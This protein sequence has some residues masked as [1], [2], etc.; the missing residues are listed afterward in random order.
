M[1]QDGYI[2]KKFLTKKDFILFKS[3]LEK[4]VRKQFESLNIEIDDL[5]QYHNVVDD[6]THYKVY[7]K[8][9]D[10]SFFDEI[11]FDIT[12]VEKRISEIMYQ[13]LQ[14]ANQSLGDKVKDATEELR[15]SLSKTEGML[16]NINKSIFSVD[17]AGK[18]LAP[19]SS[20][21]ETLFRKNIEGTNGLDLLFFHFKAESDEKKDL[22]KSFKGLFGGT[23]GTF[24]NLKEVPV[25]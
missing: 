21:S 12:L 3:E 6:D 16:L 1:K 15:A 8:L 10:S 4:F 9:Y 11:D 5:T 22:I 19:V 14:E 23:E 2:V 20:Y 7:K 17:Q 18:V 24:L 25:L 13:R